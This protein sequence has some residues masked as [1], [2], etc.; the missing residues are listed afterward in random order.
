LLSNPGSDL[1]Q[2]QKINRGLW[3]CS[4][5]NNIINVMHGPFAVCHL[6]KANQLAIIS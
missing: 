2:H 1:H 3:N 5:N 4:C 6:Q